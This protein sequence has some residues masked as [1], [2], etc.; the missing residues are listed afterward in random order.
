MN[1]L[2]HTGERLKY[3]GNVYLR[4]CHSQIVIFRIGF[5]PTG[6]MQVPFQLFR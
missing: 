5:P 3:A 2:V 1:H 6:V 4:T